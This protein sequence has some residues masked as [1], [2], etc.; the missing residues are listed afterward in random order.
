M[1]SKRTITT[2]DLPKQ[3]SLPG[4]YDGGIKSYKCFLKAGCKVSPELYADKTVVILF[5]QRIRGIG[6]L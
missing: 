3:N 1:K 6:R 5:R 2:R 4:V